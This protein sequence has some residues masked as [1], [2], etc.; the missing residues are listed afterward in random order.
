MVLKEWKR[1]VVSAAPPLRRLLAPTKR[2]NDGRV[3]LPARV[4]F[5][6][7]NNGRVLCKIISNS[8]SK[9]I[10]PLYVIFSV[11]IKTS[12]KVVF[13]GGVTATVNSSGRW[14]SATA[15]GQVGGAAAIGGGRRRRCRR[16]AADSDDD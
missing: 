13:G 10:L 5:T 16:G 9:K 6:Q 7:I 11:S 14:W 1:L 15:G 4:P 3:T 12:P 2:V 8:S